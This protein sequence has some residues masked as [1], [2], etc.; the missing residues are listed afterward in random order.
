MAADVTQ[1]FGRMSKDPQW[2][3][4]ERVAMSLVGGNLAESHCERVISAANL[5]MSDGRTLLG[6]NILEMLCV[7]R[8]NRAYLH[9]GC[10]NAVRLDLLDGSLGRWLD[11]RH[12]PP[13]L[14]PQC[15]SKIVFS[16]SLTPVSL[17]MLTTGTHS[18]T[19]NTLTSLRLCG[20]WKDNSMYLPA[21]E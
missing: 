19:R 2:Q 11:R 18:G 4:L 12:G 3:G 15:R 17:F 1:V 14:A 21:S 8:M 9:G 10:Q 5:I 6:D 20:R 7:L 16:S 13:L